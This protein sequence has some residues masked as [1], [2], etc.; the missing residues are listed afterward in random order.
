MKIQLQIPL[1]Y[2]LLFLSDPYGD[3]EIPP[4]TAAAPVTYTETCVALQITPYVDGEAD[5]TLSNVKFP[6]A[7]DPIFSGAILVPSKTISL[8]DPNRFH[9]C[10]LPITETS[11]RVTAWDYEDGN[12]RKLWVTISNVTLF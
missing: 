2:G 6:E 8:S 12:E 11:C 10:M 7:R 1:E 3:D 4:D 5:I 9:Y